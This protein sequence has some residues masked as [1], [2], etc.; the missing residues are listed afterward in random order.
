M[1]FQCDGLSNTALRRGLL[2]RPRAD[3]ET[4]PMHQVKRDPIPRAAWR[5]A[6]LGAALLAAAPLA[7]A[8]VVAT[9]VL[10]VDEPNPPLPISRL[11][12]PPP[13][14]GFAGARLAIA[15][16][17]TTGSFMGQEFTIEEVA[18][19]PDQ[20]VAALER[21][22]E[23]GVRFVATLAD[24]DT[25]LALADAAGDRALILNA[26]APDDRLRGE[27]CRPNLLHLAPSRAMLTDALAQ[28]LMVKRWDRWFLIEG[29][30]PEDKLLADSYRRSAEKFGARIVESR[31]YE[32]RGGARRT[33][34]G[35]VQIQ[36]EMPV[37]TQSAPEHDVVVAA[38][39]SDVFASWLPYHTWDA[40][41]VVGSAGLRPASWHPSQEAWAGMQLQSRF[42][43]Q[44]ARPI[45][46][47]DYNVW[48]AL[49]TIG[50]AATRTNATDP[51]TLEG[52]ILGP[53]FEMGVFKGEPATFRDWDGQLRQ[54]IVLGADNVVVSVS[55]QEPF[56]HQVSRLDTL[57]TDRPETPCRR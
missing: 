36:T 43:K 8:E 21:L 4:E 33:D 48:M 41:P 39:E 27:D 53:D 2:R 31:V 22:L 14:I 3:E 50:E 1:R 20:A 24:A 9:A 56:V 19:P 25:T 29:S 38:D 10:R 12:R 37:F 18:V 55:P 51:E 47:E 6:A 23:G 15:D 16:N 34:S 46:P 45:R 32:D 54:P 35:T 7:A 11:D 40:R 5:A 49:R 13:D 28:Y 30:H 57:G 44:S 52:Y 42:E 17:N 26:R